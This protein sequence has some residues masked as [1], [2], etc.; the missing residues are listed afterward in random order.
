MMESMAWYSGVSFLSLTFSRYYL[1]HVH[2]LSGMAFSFFLLVFLYSIRQ[3][4]IFGRCSTILFRE[5]AGHRKERVHDA[6]VLVGID[7]WITL[8]TFEMTAFS[9]TG[10]SRNK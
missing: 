1:R 4:D 9:I 3:G 10:P 6:F 7:K 8:A 2:N 5:G